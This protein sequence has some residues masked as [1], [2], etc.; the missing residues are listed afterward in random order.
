MFRPAFVARSM[1][2][3]QQSAHPSGRGVGAGAGAGAGAG[4]TSWTSEA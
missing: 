2:R 4:T 1:D 3:M